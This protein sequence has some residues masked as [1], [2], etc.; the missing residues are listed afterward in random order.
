ML[1]GS[2]V[3]SCYNQ[4]NYIEE[5]LDSILSQ[6]IDFE[7]EIVVSDDCSTDR[8]Q[9]KLLAYSNRHPG[10]IK[11]L[12]RDENVGAALNYHGV[13]KMATGDVVYHFDGDDVMLPGKLQQQYDVFKSHTDVNVVFHKAVY[14]SDDNTYS[15][16]TQYP[17][18]NTEKVSLISLQ[19]MARWGAIAVHS[20]YA[21]R[22]NSRRAI[23]EHEF[24]EWFFVIDSLLP[25]KKAAYINAPL[26]RYRCNPSA[27]SYLSTTAGKIKSYNIYLND[28]YGYFHTQPTLRTDLYS[29]FL[30]T[31]LA[32]ARSTRKCTAQSIMFLLRNLYC[33]RLTTFIETVNVRK[34]VGPGS[35]VR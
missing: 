16:E 26:V 23:I 19:E 34:R 10:R 9:E 5:C 28:L 14:F 20:S 35:R 18:A 1:T 13:H 32:M 25:D 24:M 4:E 2:V 27:G 17:D 8:T 11:L 30:V 3:V 7:C 12:L 31:F 29:N 22:R 15:S 6:E 21:Y 33:F